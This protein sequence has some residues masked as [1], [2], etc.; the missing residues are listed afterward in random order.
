LLKITPLNSFNDYWFV[1]VV[2]LIWAGGFGAYLL[3][4]FGARHFWQASRE[5]A[6]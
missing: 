4:I 1:A 2:S 3:F 6:A 5:K